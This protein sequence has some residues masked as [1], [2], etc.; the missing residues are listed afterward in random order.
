MDIRSQAF[1]GVHIQEYSYLCLLKADSYTDV[2]V[3]TFAGKL[4][5][6]FI[7]FFWSICLVLKIVFVFYCSD[8]K[9][10]TWPSSHKC[11][12]NISLDTVQS[13]MHMRVYN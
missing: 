2:L 3:M 12:I 13:L 8:V 10:N 1:G 6:D 5:N 9:V 4:F 7:C 11:I